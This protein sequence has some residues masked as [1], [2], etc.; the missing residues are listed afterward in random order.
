MQTPN[1]LFFLCIIFFTLHITTSQPK[2]STPIPSTKGFPVGDGS[3]NIV[4]DV[5]IVLSCPDA[6]RFYMNVLP[7]IQNEFI[8]NKKV[9]VILHHF[10]L[11]YHIQAFDLTITALMVEKLR[12]DQYLN[13]MKSAFEKQDLIWKNV[14]RT[15]P[16]MLDLI[17]E[18]LVKPLGIDRNTYL[19][20]I[21]E[22]KPLAVK[23]F[24]AS[25][26]RA[27]TGTPSFIVNGVKI[28]DSGA[29]ENSIENWRKLF[30]S[31]M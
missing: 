25:A 30:N 9:Q 27:V 18:Q 24:K 11:P 17:H 12:K 15:R 21:A 3:A 6:K 26:A 28:E 16:E 5:Y 22:Y 20:Y 23:E 2:Q 29:Y 31:L 7:A 8:A 1:F 14:N 19:K 4:V 10:P 13:W